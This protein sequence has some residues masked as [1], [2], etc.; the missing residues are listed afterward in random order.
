MHPLLSIAWNVAGHQAVVVA[1]L[2]AVLILFPVNAAALDGED[3]Q[4]GVSSNVS[5][6]IL[7]VSPGNCL[8]RKPGSDDR[9]IVARNTCLGSHK[10]PPVILGLNASA[11]SLG[12][13]ASA[14][15]A[16]LAR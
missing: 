3:C 15:T 10:S 2:A 16:V 5:T 9:D 8:Q 11:H 6:G 7:R 1:G 14:D 4:L 12:S 13:A